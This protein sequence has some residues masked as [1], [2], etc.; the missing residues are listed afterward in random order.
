MPSL[1]V[2]LTSATLA[3]A[4]LVIYSLYRLDAHYKDRRKGR[5]H[6]LVEI[7]SPANPK[8]ESA[9]PNPSKLVIY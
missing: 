8:F 1:A 3:F 7:S 4:T 9:N 2:T 6:G 5:P